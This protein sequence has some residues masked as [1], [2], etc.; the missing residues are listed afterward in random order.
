MRDRASTC[1]RKQEYVN[2][3]TCAHWMHISDVK[4]V[5]MHACDVRKRLW[6]PPRKELLQGRAS[7]VS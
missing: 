4:C 5:G 2:G 3:W 1:M 7:S 6:G